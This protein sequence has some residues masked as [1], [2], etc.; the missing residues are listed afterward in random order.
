M[1]FFWKPSTWYKSSKSAVF[2]WLL[3]WFKKCHP[4]GWHPRSPRH[5]SCTAFGFLL[6]RSAAA[7]GPGG[8]LLAQQAGSAPSWRLD[9]CAI[10]WRCLLRL[11]WVEIHYFWTNESY[12][13]CMSI[14]DI[15]H[16]RSI[17]WLGLFLVG[18][19][20]QEER[21]QCQLQS[22]SNGLSNSLGIWDH[23]YTFTKLH[24]WK[25]DF[26]SFL[27]PLSKWHVFEEIEIQAR[28]HNITGTPIVR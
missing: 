6:G 26:N 14:C 17:H 15:V 9:I 2:F 13:W 24:R 12:I 27:F 23:L 22:I 25:W 21:N 1:F 4:W 11:K 10:S 8:F 28:R 7:R 20:V 18:N 5:G 16:I 19:N 3:F